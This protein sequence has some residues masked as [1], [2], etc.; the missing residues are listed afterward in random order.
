VSGPREA[1]SLPALREAQSWMPRSFCHATARSH[2]NQGRECGF[3]RTQG[4]TMNMANIQARCRQ[5]SVL[6]RGWAPGLNWGSGRQ[7]ANTS[8]TAG[9][10]ETQHQRS[11]DEY[12]KDRHYPDEYL[13]ARRAKVIEISAQCFQAPED[14]VTPDH[15]ADSRNHGA[16]LYRISRGGGSLGGCFHC[17]AALWCHVLEVKRESVL[18]YLPCGAVFSGGHRLQPGPHRGPYRHEQLRV[19][20][21]SFR[22]T[23]LSQSFGRAPHARC[24]LINHQ[25]DYITNLLHLVI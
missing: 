22:F 18:N 12:S 21:D 7:A 17:A 1:G 11:R 6:R 16:I 14:D 23:L 15:D 4:Q 8:G 13:L 5:R 19:V 9:H 25:I 3:Q 10:H 2:D 24:L 20:A